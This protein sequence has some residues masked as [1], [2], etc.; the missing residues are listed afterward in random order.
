[1]ADAP[2]L[3]PRKT[4]NY[5]KRDLTAALDCAK[6][7]GIEVKRIDIEN[8]RLSIVMGKPDP[9]VGPNPFDGAEF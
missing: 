8:G 5:S 4:V 1:M 3:R 9:E 2:T 7:A 6:K